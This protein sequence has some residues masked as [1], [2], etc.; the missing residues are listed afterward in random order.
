MGI[1]NRDLDVSEQKHAFSECLGIVGTGLTFAVLVVPF[2]SKLVSGQVFSVGVSGS[3]TGALW[4]NRFIAGAGITTIAMATLALT[5]FG[6]SGGQSLQV[7]GPTVFPGNTFPL[8][9]GDALIWSSAG[10][11][12]AAAITFTLVLQALQDFRSNLGA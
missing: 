3:P 7:N 9:P 6:T 10:A 11:N 5:A 1:A 2:A 12:A 8:L 4:L